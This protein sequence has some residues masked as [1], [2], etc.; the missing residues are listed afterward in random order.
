MRQSEKALVAVC[1]GYFGGCVDY[2]AYIND[3]EKLKRTLAE[4]FSKQFDMDI[5]PEDIGCLGCHGSIHKPWCASC[6][7]RQ[8][9]E[10]KGI[11]TCAFCDEFPC[12]KLEKYYEKDKCGDKFRAHILRQKEIGLEKWLE[13][14]REKISSQEL[15]DC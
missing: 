6:S 15:S 1:G 9:T 4:E 12:E 13:E 7:I 11:L 10:K 14:M 3:D 8:C 2:L 5:K